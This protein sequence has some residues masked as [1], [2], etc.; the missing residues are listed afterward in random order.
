MTAG[1]THA[2]NLL[3]TVHHEMENSVCSHHIYKSV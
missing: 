1:N 2:A 3:D